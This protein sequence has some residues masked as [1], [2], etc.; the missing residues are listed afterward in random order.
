MALCLNSLLEI[1]NPHWLNSLNVPTSD[2][3]VVIVE[4][5]V[6]HLPVCLISVAKQTVYC[7]KVAWSNVGQ[8]KRENGRGG[9]RKQHN[10][11]LHVPYISARSAPL[12]I[13]KNLMGQPC[14][15]Y[16]SL[17]ECRQRCCSFILNDKGPIGKLKFRG[18]IILK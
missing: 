1:Y 16:G 10:K 15:T 12:R 11:A 4:P 2:S 3:S 14:G 18:R 6:L 8:D 9:Y 17:E 5:L 13:Q 7:F